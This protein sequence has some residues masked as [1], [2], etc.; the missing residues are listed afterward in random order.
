M[1]ILIVED[2]EDFREIVKSY[3]QSQDL[4]IELFEAAS[5][6]LG[7]VKALREKPHIVLMD[8]RLPNINGIDAANRIRQYLPDCKIIILTM[9]ETAAFR[10]TFKSDGIAA[11]IG[12]SE[13]YDKLGPLLKKILA[14]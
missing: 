7:I 5:G 1:K 2:H 10:S 14:E 13:L 6:E 9:F 11:Y 8:I 3:L 12:K 4:N